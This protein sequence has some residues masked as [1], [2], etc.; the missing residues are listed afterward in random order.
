MAMSKEMKKLWDGLNERQRSFADLYISNI[1]EI[2]AGRLSAT[3]V[4]AML[5]TECNKRIE[6]SKNASRYLADG[7]NV[8]MYIDAF[9]AESARWEVDGLRTTEET[10][11]DLEAMATADITE[12]VSWDIR[13]LEDGTTVP[14]PKI[15]DYR[16]VPPEIRRLIRSVTFTK[17]GPKIELH[18]QLK[19]QDMLN[20]MNGAYTDKVEVSGTVGLKVSGELELKVDETIAKLFNNM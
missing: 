4:Y 12:L 16:N 7:N 3:D 17:S 11:R 15:M 1:V 19:A 9:F 14:I 18:D 10:K 13:E 2:V 8:R 6:C 5:G 20:R